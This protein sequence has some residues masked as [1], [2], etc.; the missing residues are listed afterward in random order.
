MKRKEQKAQKH[1]FA[2]DINRIFVL[3]FDFFFYA[4]NGSCAKDQ[5]LQEINKK[6]KRSSRQMKSLKRCWAKS[7]TANI[8]RALHGKNSVMCT[9]TNGSL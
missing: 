1:F 2:S 9:L 8:S 3:W 4:S 6:S 5:E 7:I